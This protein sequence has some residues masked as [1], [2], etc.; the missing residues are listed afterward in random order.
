[1]TPARS[2]LPRPATAL[3]LPLL[4][5]VVIAAAAWLALTGRGLFAPHAHPAGIDGYAASVAFWTLMMVAMMLP[6]LWPWVS[7]FG[8][9][10]P[11]AYPG[12]SSGVVV[13]Q[14][15][16]GY[17]VVW[18]GYSAAAAALQGGLQQAALLR[19]DLSTGAT[20]GGVLLVVA[21]VFQLTPLKDAC[22]AHC[23]S[24]LSFF[25]ARWDGGPSGPFRM[26]ARHGVFCVGCCWAMMALAFVLG[27]MNLLW[28]AVLTAMIVA[29]QRTPRR[30]RLRQAFGVALAAWGALLL[31]VR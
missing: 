30:W 19:L 8:S 26:G 18:L 29:E 11:D 7:L 20:V 2:G 28:M 9:M 13:A 12:R 24:P 16:A 3:H 21:G 22:L 15:G 14:F 10:A 27:I 5:V 31:L 23:R 6:A 1:M 17:F 25:L 4:C